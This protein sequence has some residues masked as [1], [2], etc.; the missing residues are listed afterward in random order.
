MALFGGIDPGFT[1]NVRIEWAEGKAV[2]RR[3][4]RRVE[5]MSWTAGVGYSEN[6]SSLAHH[7]KA[8]ATFP[9]RNTRRP[10]PLT[11]VP[12]LLFIGERVYAFPYPDRTAQLVNPALRLTRRHSLSRHPA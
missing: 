6:F 10:A 2:A 8:L 12:T 11:V 4:E 5:Y 7:F 9:G 1:E 3:R